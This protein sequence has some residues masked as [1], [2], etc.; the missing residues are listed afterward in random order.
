MEEIRIIK[1]IRFSIIGGNS[2][3]ANYFYR[4]AKALPE[5]FHISGAVVRNEAKAKEIEGKWDIRTYPTL[6]DLLEKETPD[7]VVVSVPPEA[8]AKYLIE[9]AE[10]N[11]PA[12][13]ETPPASD[14]EG[15]ILLH[16]KLTLRGAKVQVAEQYPLHPIQQARNSIIDSGLLG[17]V[18]EATVSI[19]HFYHGISLIRKMLQA[20]FQNAEIRGKGF[21]SNIVSGPSR[22]GYPTEEKIDSVTRDL[23]WIDFGYKL[24]IYDFTDNQHRSWIRSNHLS[25]R[26]DR[27]EIFDNQVHMLADYQTPVHIDLKRIN[28]GEYENHEGYFL[29][30]ILAGENWVYQNPFIPARLY[31]DEIAIAHCLCKMADYIEGGPSFYS[32]AEAS[33][34]HYL[35]MKVEEAVKTGNTIHTVSQPWTK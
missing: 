16:E 24:G 17:K 21:R 28:K 2:F 19:S 12:L 23:A 29:Y 4:I 15:L 32:L 31:D 11:M 1:K 6:S 8:C 30:G 13:A 5:Q 22:A 10:L 34:D 25:V 14:L 35:G 26:G 27:G 20:G 18:T 3:R 33:Q 9:L 7:F